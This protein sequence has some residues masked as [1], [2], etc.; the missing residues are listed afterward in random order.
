Y[1]Q[2]LKILNP[3]QAEERSSNKAKALEETWIKPDKTVEY[4]PLL[5]N[6]STVTLDIEIPE[7]DDESLKND[8]EGISYVPG[9]PPEGFQDPNLGLPVFPQPQP[10]SP[11]SMAVQRER[12]EM[13]LNMESLLDITHS[14]YPVYD[15]PRFVGQDE[16]VS[17][18]DDLVLGPMDVPPP[19]SFKKLYVSTPLFWTELMD[20]Y[21]VPKH[22]PYYMD[23]SLRQKAYAERKFIQDSLMQSFGDLVDSSIKLIRLSSS[24]YD[25]RLTP[26]SFPKLSQRVRG[27]KT[28][29]ELQKDLGKPNFPMMPGF[30]TRV[31]T[32]CK[33][34]Y[35]SQ[36]AR[37]AENNILPI[38][39]YRD[40]EDDVFPI[41]QE[42]V[43]NEF[44][45]Q[46]EDPRYIERE[47]QRSERKKALLVHRPL[48]VR[49]HKKLRNQDLVSTNFVRAD[50]RRGKMRTGLSTR[51]IK[52]KANKSRLRR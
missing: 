16:E 47:T 45:N 7:S 13:A 8:T 24:P 29:Q 22:D 46:L 50:M 9:T 4:K 51:G 5:R 35:A 17:S 33:T 18:E 12:L 14:L 26:F 30:H 31:R 20:K 52:A 38:T 2:E 49:I 21:V 32:N 15:P 3:K 37:D 27:Y 43:A 39:P 36:L 34:V 10:L 28:M 42:P 1:P 40:W 44:P 11:G 48:P 23:P 19:P 6:P 41:P 25:R